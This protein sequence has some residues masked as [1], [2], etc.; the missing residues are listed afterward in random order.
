MDFQSVL[1]N[2]PISVAYATEKETPAITTILETTTISLMPISE[3][4][5]SAKPFPNTS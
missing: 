2:V 3:N 1:F 4:T 5:G